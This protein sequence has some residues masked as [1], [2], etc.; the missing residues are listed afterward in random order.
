M[1]QVIKK[2]IPYFLLDWYHFVLVFLAALFYGFPSK[3]LKVIGITGTNGKSTVA[4]MISVILQEAGFKIAVLSSIKF[5]IADKEE[6]N[7]LKMTMP[8]RFALQR[9]LKQ[10]VNSGCKYAVIEVTS[11]GI[12]QHRHRFIKFD[13][14]VFTNLSPEHIEAHGSFENYRQV[15]EK[16]FAVA[17]GVHVLN[18]DDKNVEYFLKYNAEK[19]YKY[20]L[21]N[22][23][24][25]NKEYEILATKYKAD[26]SGIG[27]QINDV[28]FELDVLG[29][30][31][32]YNALASVCVALSEKISLE[33]CRDALKKIKIVP[34][35]MEMVIFS[36]F[37]VIV[38][39]AFTP[40]A[41]EKV[42][43]TV[44]NSF[45]PENLI[46]VLGAAGGGRDKW[47]RPILG[48]IAAKYCQHIII[49]NEDPYDE[50]PED[51]IN[52][53][54]QGAGNKAEKI[55]DRE[56]AINSALE[57]AKTNDVVIITG[58]GCEPWICI[59]KGKK[60]PWDDRKIVKQEFEKLNYGI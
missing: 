4:E 9:F 5:K 51:I 32:I 56:K 35:R 57:K 1:K 26:A 42:Y 2:I 14:A 23:G 25:N 8:G 34:G 59:E 21:L 53:V 50:N 60:I 39:Y 11:E 15:K 54:A 49:T 29:A 58:K 47:K 40:N 45:K 36:P 3:K 10:A 18:I 30:F 12:K 41:L 19:K 44:K 48:K 37:K 6:P 20:G 17:K 7:M 27:F 46:C 22:N 52:Q 13:T 55:I 31:N 43:T 28:V 38:D 16:L 33:T 24:V